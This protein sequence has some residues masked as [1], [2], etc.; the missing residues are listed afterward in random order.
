V[1]K[2]VIDHSLGFQVALQGIPVIEKPYGEIPLIDSAAYQRSAARALA[3]KPARLTGSEVRFL[4]LHH[5]LTYQAMATLLGVTYL[6]VKKWE[7][8]KDDPTAMAWA[9]EVM[10]RGYVLIKQN[11]PPARVVAALRRFYNGVF[12]APEREEVLPLS[13]KGLALR[14][15]ADVAG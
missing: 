1:R 11:L 13:G 2:N 5:E 8:C 6:A 12:P 3:E 14:H 15:E 9:T 4:R 10:L 7:A